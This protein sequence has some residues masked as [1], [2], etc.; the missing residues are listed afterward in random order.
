MKPSPSECRRTRLSSALWR[1]KTRKRGQREYGGYERRGEDAAEVSV[2][3]KM[4]KRLNYKVEKS[5]TE[6]F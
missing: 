5:K 1:S 4:W 6:I 2:A 3:N